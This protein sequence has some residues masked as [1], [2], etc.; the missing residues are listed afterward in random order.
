MAEESAYHSSTHPD[1]SNYIG[2][3][4]A[5]GGEAGVVAWLRTDGAGG[6]HLKAGMWRCEE[7]S[8]FPY[9]FGVDETFVM[10]EG[11]LRVALEDGRSWDFGPGETAS[12]LKGTRSTWR[13]VEPVLHFFIQTD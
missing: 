2:F 7:E 8:E 4:G 10:I 6:R 9:L 1:E 12:F 13:V 3:V 5:E 11:V